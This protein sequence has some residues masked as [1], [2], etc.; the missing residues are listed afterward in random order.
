VV[1]CWQLNYKNIADVWKE[2]LTGDTNLVNW[3]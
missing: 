1:G 2:L 3:N